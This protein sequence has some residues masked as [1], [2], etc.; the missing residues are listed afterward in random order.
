VVA[1]G[2]AVG[3][4]VVAVG[5]VV[6]VAVA[7]AVGVVVV[8]VG[9]VVVVVVVVDIQIREQFMNESDIYNAIA[10]I[11]SAPDWA[12][13][14][15]VANGTGGHIRRRADA[16][17]MSLWPSRGLILRGFEIKTARADLKKELK[18]PEKAETVAAFCD[19]WYL[20][21][22]KGLV[23]DLELEVPPAWGLMEVG[24]NGKIRTAKKAV[25][26]DAKPIS[27]VLLAAILRASRKEIDHIEENYVRR[28]DIQ[29]K[30]NAARE[31]GKED[32]PRAAQQEIAVLQ[33]YKNAVEEFAARTGINLIENG[34]QDYS[35]QYAEALLVGKAMV[36]KYGSGLVGMAPRIKAIADIVSNAHK[37]LTQLLENK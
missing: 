24:D 36:G 8:A 9:V 13:F 1:V 20:A 10:A 14:P 26:T 28:E 18:T 6:V 3:V 11:H 17:A 25:P 31:S 32:A 12:C 27:R 30:I 7:V 16:V 23:K 4:V 34:W 35:T 21:T 37:E 19:E 33:R 15:D 2:V 22:P 5:V 29:G